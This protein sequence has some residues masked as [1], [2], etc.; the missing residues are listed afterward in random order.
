[1]DNS[2]GG[3]GGVGGVERLWVFLAHKYYLELK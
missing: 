3:G 1:M 2:E